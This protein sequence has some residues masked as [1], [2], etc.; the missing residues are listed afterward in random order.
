MQQNTI[1]T[2]P[3]QLQNF[4]TTLNNYFNA[5][6]LVKITVGNKRDTTADLKNVFIKPVLIKAVVQLSFTY[7]YAT[8]DITKNFSAQVAIET[9]NE[10][11]HHHFFNM[12]VYTNA[13]VYYFVAT[14]KGIITI[15]NKKLAAPISAINTE[16]NKIK[17]RL[18]QAEKN[19]YL[20]QLGITNKDGLVKKEMQH[21][22]KQI[23]RYVEIIEGILKGNDSGNT[24]TVADM[25]SGKGYLTFALYDYLQKKLALAP[26]ITGIEMRDDLIETCNAIASLCKY[27]QLTFTK[28]TIVDVPI[29][30]LDMLIAL[31][32]CDT[33]TDDAIFKG[34]Q[35]NATYI[36][37]APCC[38][39]QIRKQ[40]HTAN[41]CF[42]T[43]TKHGILLE[44]QAEILTD[45]IRALLM[46]AH[47]Y[48]TTVFDFI[49]TEHTPKNVLIVGIKK[50]IIP[51]K[52]KACLEQLEALKKQFGITTH[53]LETLLTNN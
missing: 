14:A 23:N 10:L 38:H 20:Q 13:N 53:Y 28:G 42:N 11:L 32:A 22:Y 41:T 3:V 1:F 27:T 12:D 18:I 2:T 31:H 16:H 7:R 35:A 43:I 21:K 37:C 29:K 6:E 52:K 15:K 39:K 40:I 33:A 8:K 44:R 30:K 25:G 50:E 48:K 47:G 26:I 34:M 4:L 17:M 46:E 5:N 24:F 49:E 51:E 36:V 9:I 45:S 19:V